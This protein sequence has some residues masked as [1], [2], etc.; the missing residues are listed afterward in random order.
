MTSKNKAFNADLYTRAYPDVAA[1]GMDPKAHYE[2]YGRLFGRDPAPENGPFRA[3]ISTD[4]PTLE[5][6]A[7]KSHND[8]RKFAEEGAI[9]YWSRQLTT[10][11][12]QLNWFVMTATK[13]K[14][15]VARDVL[16]HAV[17]KARMGRYS[18]FEILLERLR[19]LDF[20]DELVK[21]LKPWLSIFALRRMARLLYTQ[22]LND[23]DI[24]NAL[25]IY[26]LITSLGE[27]ATLDE[28]DRSYHADLLVDHREYRAARGILDKKP[29]AQ[30]SRRLGWE[31]LRLNCDNP[32]LPG[33]DGNPDR[34][35]AGL[36]ALY[37]ERGFAPIRFAPGDGPAFF[38]LRGEAPLVT[39]DIP[40][41]SIIMPIYEPDEA[42]DLA[43]ASLLSQSWHNI[44]I[45]AVDDCSPAT[46]VDGNPTNYR[47]RLEAWARYDPRFRV[48]FNPTNCG[49]YFA[50]NTGYDVAN[51]KYITIA[52]K[53]DWHHPQKI[54]FQAK[55]ME[56]EP[57][58]VVNMLNWVRVNENMR[59]MVRWGPDRVV[60][61]SFASLF[62]RREML[63]EKFGYWDDVRKSADGEMKFRFQTY[64][65]IDI[66]PEDPLPFAF[67]L[68][69]DDNLTSQDLGLGYENDDRR[70]YHLSCTSWHKKIKAKEDLPY[71]PRASEGRKFPAPNSFLPDKPEMGDFDV[72]ILSEFGFEAGNSTIL[73]NELQVAVDAGLRVGIIPCF[74][75]LIRS[76]SVRHMTPAIQEMLDRGVV[77]RVPLAAKIQTKLLIIRWP[78]IMQIPHGGSCNIRTDNLI[79]ISNHAP[80]EKLDD[81]ISYDVTTVSENA[82]RMFGI[83]P[84]WFPESEQIGVILKRIVAPGE[85]ADQCWK[86]IVAGPFP[87][88][89]HPDFTLPPVIG[90]HGR[91]HP[92]KW[93]G[94]RA[95]LIAA[96]PVD[97]SAR[98]SI[99]GGA[100]TPVKS[101]LMTANEAAHWTVHTL[102]AIP[103]QDYLRELDFF[104]YFHHE[105][106]VE[107]FGMTIVEAMSHGCICILPEN[108][109]AVFG[110]AGVYCT[111][112]ETQQTIAGLWAEPSRFE[113]QQRRARKFVHENA[114]PEAYLRRLKRYGIIVLESCRH[115]L[116]AV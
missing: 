73:R 92:M 82:A 97:G 4:L 107:A 61:P 21:T 103:V 33:A 49:A 113:A 50:R 83:R 48:I 96:Y 100:S 11:K 94:N 53:D 116:G 6:V 46:D 70:A 63:R 39:G 17:S 77:T 2:K 109:K 30:K 10:N 89:R 22:R 19:I 29:A 58:R 65:G 101:G 37:E 34:W 69:G 85:L 28:I 52:D 112:A 105:N 15:V 42:T 67:S 104:V 87:E 32:E 57:D 66:Q 114:S 38:R 80:Y 25:T 76:A 40:L 91:D 56:A 108:F 45:I 47:E 60:H 84:I 115:S 88:M 23:L 79:V 86:G 41:V 90:R 62:Y 71:L 24:L 55:Q 3:K 13:T 59:F 36:N 106:L 64:F 5:K 72:L 54:E 78:S 16:T 110:D 99:L 93:P 9:G 31:F 95:D 102:N 1:S 7:A 27:E 75:F 8:A 43:I 14:S 51:G 12:D 81:R 74:N 98:V 26:R 111:P 44:E 20:E 68:M 35:I 18:E